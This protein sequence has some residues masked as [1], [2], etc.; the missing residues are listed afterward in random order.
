MTKP[1]TSVAVM[2]LV[3]SGR[4]KLDEPAGNYL[5]E[6]SQVQVLEEFDATTGKAKLRPAKAPPTVRQLLS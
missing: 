5:P 3:E 6:L 2:Q 4:V 1:I